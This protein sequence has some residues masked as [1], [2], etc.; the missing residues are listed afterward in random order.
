MHA[1]KHAHER[2]R[3]HKHT[4]TKTY[5]YIYTHTR[6]KLVDQAL[7][8]VDLVKRFCDTFASYERLQAWCEEQ[9]AAQQGADEQTQDV[10]EHQARGRAAIQGREDAAVRDSD[11]VPAD[12]VMKVRRERNWAG[13][14]GMDGSSV[15]MCA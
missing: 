6:L 14:R 10:Q 8:K 12:A 11:G 15:C 13:F 2:A 7:N 1:C 5:M 9:Q 4:N 3:T